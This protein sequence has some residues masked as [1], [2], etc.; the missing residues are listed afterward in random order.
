MVPEI[1]SATDIIFC[2]MIPEIWS[3]TDRI[4]SH[5]GPFFAF[6]PSP[7]WQPKELKFWK[8]EKRP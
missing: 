7:P 5:F 2:H 6:Y 8:N 1:P 4:F 3:A